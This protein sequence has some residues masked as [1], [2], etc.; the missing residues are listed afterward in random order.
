MGVKGRVDRGDLVRTAA[1]LSSRARHARD[2]GVVLGWAVNELEPAARA[3][4]LPILIDLVERG[5]TVLVIEPIARRLV[6]WW[7][8]WRDAFL[9]AGGRADELRFPVALPAALADLDEAAG[10]KRDELT[11]RT[12]LGR[13]PSGT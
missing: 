13:V 8:D 7:N 4:L 9:R 5:A 3:R 2:L 10:F 11:A 12:L 1:A 6:P